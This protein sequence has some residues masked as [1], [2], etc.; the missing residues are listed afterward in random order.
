MAANPVA[1]TTTSPEYPGVDFE[2]EVV[3]QSN[4]ATPVFYVVSRKAAKM[5]N[6][7]QD[8]LTETEG[9]EKT[10]ANSVVPVPNV[11]GNVLKYV[12]EW[13][14]YHCENPMEEIDKPLRGRLQ[15]W[16]CAFDNAY[17]YTDLIKNGD[18]RQ[19]ELLMYVIMA[20]NFL[21]IK[22][23]L[24]LT[25]AAVANIMKGKTVSEERDVF[26]LKNDTI[27]GDFTKEQYERI[28]D[29]DQYIEDA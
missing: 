18:E 24:E 2:N 21:G 12:I 10:A 6:V 29:E 22:D 16:I 14:E 15:D 7:I 27:Y 9:Q 20:A 5:S 8:Y 1:R 26:G 25:C 11:N 23:L 17:L 19:H 3:L 28:V 4:D 13:I